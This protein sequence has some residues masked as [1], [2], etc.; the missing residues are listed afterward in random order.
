MKELHFILKSNSIKDLLVKQRGILTDHP[1]YSV[2]MKRYFL[3]S[4]EQFLELPPEQGAVSYIVQPPLDG[5]VVGVWLY[6]VSEVEMEYRD[7][8]TVARDADR[9]YVWHG[10][11]VASGV[12]SAEQTKEILE[13]FEENLDSRGMSIEFNCVR[14]WFFIDDIDN[15][16]AGMVVARRDNF[17]A[18]GLTP[19]THYIASTGIA[20]ASPFPG[21]F[22]QMDAY[23]VKGN[24]R[25]KYL[26]AP[27]NM[28]PT[29]EYGVT[30][31]RGVKLDFGDHFQVLISGTASIDNKGRVLHSGNVKAQAERM[32]ENVTALLSEA[33]SGWDDVKQAIVY[34]R[35]ASDYDSVAPLLENKLHK[36]P[37][38]ITLAPVC[39]PDWLIEMECI[40]FEQ[41]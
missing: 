10:S 39:R 28:N 21:S 8:V 14:T 32:F 27:A 18:N 5:S 2:A 25:Q 6:L 29:Y 11:L 22:V 20:G 3:S 33:G 23:S 1:G 37:Y 13:S 4:P 34:L 9:Q 41:S 17:E 38:I 24:F 40:A 7:N 16:Y 15:N 12:D 35:N 36:I 31:E 19:Q 26:Y 30:F